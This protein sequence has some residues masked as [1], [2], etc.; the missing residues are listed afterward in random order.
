MCFDLIDLV[1]CKGRCATGTSC[2]FLR[3][4]AQTLSELSG[5]LDDLDP[6]VALVVEGGDDLLCWSGRSPSQSSSPKCRTMP[7]LG[8]KV[9]PKLSEKPKV[10]E[11]AWAGTAAATRATG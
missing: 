11:A 3:P 5:L 7:P 4:I 9:L 1:R 8:L 10:G 6:V 2:R